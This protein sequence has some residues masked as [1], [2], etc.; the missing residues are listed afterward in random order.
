MRKL[1]FLFCVLISGSVLAQENK[2]VVTVTGVGKVEV[3]PDKVLIK[4]R[5]E[6]QGASAQVVKQQNEAVVNDIFEFLESMGIPAENIQTE[7]L[8]LDKQHNY[9]TKEYYF[10]A[11]QAISIQ[12]ND[13][14]KYEEIMSGLM[15]S[16][17]NRIDGIE[18]GTSKQEELESQARKEAMLDA[19]E[20][21]TQLATAIGQETG[22]AVLIQEMGD[23]HFQP[24]YRVAGMASFDTA[25]KTIAPGEMEITVKVNVSFLLS[26]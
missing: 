23:G 16:G 2:P 4:A 10:V 22:P 20:K 7:Y 24:V 19:K 18:F 3:V 26:N 15:D 25:A 13:L 6:H 9:E 5:V 8:R 21:A 11:N 1:L 12:L 14:E 17:L